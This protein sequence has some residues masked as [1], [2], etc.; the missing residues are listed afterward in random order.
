[1]T[2]ST[3]PA[4]SAAPDRAAAA[5]RVLIIA[6][7]LSAVC[8]AMFL[9]DRF[10]PRNDELTGSLVGAYPLRVR[11]MYWAVLASWVL[12]LGTVA[13]W[14][15]AGLRESAAARW[16]RARDPRLVIAAELV[17]PFACYPLAVLL[18]HPLLLLTCV[19]STAFAAWGV[20]HLQRYRRMP[21]RIPAFAFG[22]GALIAAGFG[23]AMNLLYL[24]DT[25]SIF[26]VPRMEQ[27]LTATVENPRGAEDLIR[28]LAGRG[29]L[30]P[31]AHSLVTAIQ[32]IQSGLALDAGVF[33]ELAKGAGI[34]ILFLLCRRWF[35][36]PVSG[37][38]LGA[39]VG[40]GFNLAE[41]VDYMSAG[42]AVSQYWARQTVGLMGSHV[43]FTALTG[44]GFGIAG[45]LADRRS[46]RL[47][48]GCG[49]AAA[50]GAHFMNDVCLG[51]LG[52][53]EQGWFSPSPTMFTL[54]IQPV[55]LLVLQGPFVAAYAL[56]LRRGGR[57]QAA[58]L[59][60]ELAV[61]A[62]AGTGAVN[63]A[64]IP[65]LLD[66]GRRFR[67]RVLAF[68]RRGG[69]GAYRYLGRL[70]AAQLDLATERWHRG[71]QPADPWGP[72]EAELRSRV[73][74]LKRHPAMTDSPAVRRRAEARA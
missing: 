28:W 39:L 44:A 67:L 20:Y 27:V 64:E 42:D 68:R 65:I 53:A 25:M 16:L 50:I 69:I 46:R 60:R 61:E 48:I 51:A 17:V 18:A 5:R 10:R 72:G 26:L 70:Q 73:L 38:V 57:H 33:E 40:L 59:A 12:A 32:F 19:P 63:A 71:R 4:A 31:S 2:R 1:M 62:R 8:G 58:G 24:A 34:A 35:D 45:Q 66:P 14:R 49:L 54:V 11:V 37:I 43:A 6:V 74:R 13:V 55:T 7:L 52:R 41:S 56:L 30:P 21:V 9:A 36:G 3:N 29:P 47:V 22:W 15:G 23:G